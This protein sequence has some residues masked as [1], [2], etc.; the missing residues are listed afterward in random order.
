MLLLPAWAVAPPLPED[1]SIVRTASGYEA[2]VEILKAPTAALAADL[3]CIP[4]AHVRLLDV[5][6]RMDVPVVLFGTVSAAIPQ[7]ALQGLRLANQ[8]ELAQVLRELLTPPPTPA[9]A[10]KPVAP[11]Q[12]QAAPA[13]LTSAK[14]PAPVPP[15]RRAIPVPGEPKSAARSSEALTPEELRALLGDTP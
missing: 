12:S 14:T 6:A 4:S 1:V 3:A 9:E 8:A 7:A 5:A 2:A 11:A 10:P 13:R 15:P